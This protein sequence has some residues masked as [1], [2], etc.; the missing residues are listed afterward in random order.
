MNSV[1]VIRS[2]ADIEKFRQE[3]QDEMGQTDAEWWQKTDP[4]DPPFKPG[5]KV[6][7]ENINCNGR[8]DAEMIR[9]VREVQTVES[10]M[11]VPCSN[12]NM[13]SINLVGTPLMF[14]PRD[15]RKV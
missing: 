14:M 3:L 5:D 9:L 2:D 11:P 13:W 15:L 4:N 8:M 1:T 7:V 12:T 6:M 10:L